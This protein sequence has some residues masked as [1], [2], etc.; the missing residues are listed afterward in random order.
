MS[1]PI[2]TSPGRSGFGPVLSLSYDSGSGNGPFGFGWSLSTPSIT[3]KTDKGL[4][5]Y[6]DKDESDVYVLSGAEDLVPVLDS[7]GKRFIDD[8]TIPGYTI[9]RYRPRVE[10]LFAQIERWTRKDDGDIH[11]RSIS[12]DNILTIYGQGD[13]DAR[14]S[15]P[16]D[17]QRIFAWLICE[18]RDDKGNAVV[19]DYKA[20]DGAGTDI[21]RAHQR[22]RG[23]RKDPGR[24]ANRYLKRIRYGNRRTLLDDGKRP[25][26]F[27][28]EQISAAGWMF[29]VVFDYGEHDA[30][31]P[32][33]DDEGEW[34]T[35]DDPFS[36]YRSGFE[37]RTARLCRRVLM[38]HHFPDE[39]GVGDNCL[40]RS[41]DFTYSEQ[42][43]P[44]RSSGPVYTFLCAATQTGYQRA[45]DGYRRRSLPPV[46]FEYTK[47]VIQGVVE[48]ADPESIEN[49]PIGLDG[50]AYRWTDLHGEGIPGILSEQAGTWFYKRNLSPIPETVI[51]GGEKVKARFAALEIVAL[52]PN[53]SLNGEAE[54]MDLAGDGR[55]DVV[56]MDGLA[57]GLYGHDDA[58]GWYPFRS[59]TAPLNRELRD[60][61]AKFIDLDGDGHA[62]LLITEDGAFVWH[63]SLAE[64]GFSTARRVA[65]ALD[66]EKGPRIVFAD[67]TQSIYLADLSGDGLTDIVRL[68]NGEVCYWPNLGYGRFGAKVTMDNSPWF[69]QQDQFDQARIRLADIDG[70]GTTDIIY[71]HRDG[72]RLYFNQSGNGWSLPKLLQVFPRVHDLAGIVPLDLLGNGTA[73]LVWSSPLQGD[74]SRPLSY[75]NLVGEHKPHLLIG[76]NNNLGAETRI[77]YAPSTKF[78]LQDK[79]DGRPWITR[80][81]F[82]V[83]VV[84]RVETYDH[85]SRSRFATRYAYH[86]G[87]FDGVEREFRGF[88]MVEQWDTEQF[89]V[90]AGG[91]IPADNI[92]AASHVP[93]IHTKSWFHTGVY[94]RRDHVSDYFAGLL[95][96]TDQGE[97]FR[98]QGLT[99]AEARALLLP[100]TILPD[101][102]TSKEEREACRALKGSM[103]RQEVYAD[104]A[105]PEATTEQIRRAA[106][107]YTV[108]E[109]SFAI[110][111]L[112]RVGVNRHAVIFVHSCEAISYHYE[113][114]SADPRTQ[115][116][117]TLEVDEVGN[118]RKQAVIG[119]G[120][121]TQIRIIN[122]EGKP[123]LV[124]NF[125]L[126]E[127]HPTDQA[128]QTTSLLTY[129]ES[130]FTEAIDDADAYRSP[131]PC[132]AITFEL[133]GYEAT[134]P[135]GRF[136][137]SDLVEPNPD[138][139]ATERFLHRFAKPDVAYEAVA[140]GN[141]RRRPIEKLRTLYRRDDLSGLLPLGK[142]EPLALPGESYKLALTPGLLTQVFQRRRPDQTFEDLLPD[143]IRPA[144]LGGL[145]GDQ[146]GYV[147]SQTLKADGRFPENDANDHWWVPSG[148]LFHHPDDALSHVELAEARAHFFLPR[149]YHD[150]FGHGAV[151]DFDAHDLLMVEARDALNN[152]VTADINDYRVLQPRRISDPN[153]NQT[154][155]AFDIL[156]MVAGTAVMGKPD[157]NPRRGDNLAGFNPDLAQVELDAFIAAPCQPN[158]DPKRTEAAPIVHTLLQGATTRIVYDLDRYKRVGEPPFAA[159]IVRE[160]H[161]CDLLPG[162]KSRL[163]IS[164]TYS[165]GFGREIQKKIQAE[166]GALDI[167]DPASPVVNPRW[168]GSGWTIF[169][170]K[171]KP[172]RQY[173]P[174]FDD[175]HAFKFATIHGVSPVL[176][177]DPAE[178]VIATLHPNHTYTKVKF[179]PWQQ[180]SWDVN[181]TCAPP[182]Q[183]PGDPP[184]HETGD[185]RTDP[186]ILGVVA[187]YFKSLAADPLGPWKTWHAQRIGGGLGTEEKTAAEQAAAHADTPTTVHFDTLGRP[188]LTV[189]RNRVVCEG[190][191]LHGKPDEEFRN[192]VEL[193]IEG[194]QRQVFDERKLPDANNL[195]LGELQQRVIMQYAYDM[196]SNRIYQLSME[197]GAR[198]M[199]NDVSGKPICAWDSRGHKFT[200]SYDALRRPIEQYVRGA[201]SDADPLKPN[202]DPRTLN[203]PSELGL[204]VDK[205]EY[206]EPPL[207]ATAA[208]DVEAQRLNLRT[209]IVRHSDSA[210]IAT[211]ARLDAN[212]KPTEAY[213][214][215]GNLLRS[216]RQ[217][218][219]DYKAIPDWLQS[220][221]IDNETFEGSTRY[222]ALNRPIQSVAPRSS[223]GRGKFNVIQPVFNEANLLEGLNVWLER[224]TSPTAL[225]DPANELPSPVGVADID[226]DAKGQRTRIDY[227]TRDATV[228]RTTYA[229][230]RDT[231]R[232]THLYTRRGVNPATAQGVAFTDD[233]D[234]PNPPPATIAAP[235]TPP[236][237]K[238][239][240][241]QSLHYTYDPVGNITRIRDDAQQ[242]LYFKNRRVE[243]H[244]DYVYD[245]LYRLIQAEGREHLGQAGAPIPHAYNDAGRVGILSANPAGRFSP[246][247]HSAMGH[248]AERYVYDAVGNFLQMQHARDHTVVSDWTRVYDYGEASLIEAGKQSNRMI[249]ATIGSG[250]PESYRH[251]AHGNMLDAPHLQA[252]QWDYRD[253]FQ[254]AQRQKI[255]E[256]DVH[257]VERQGERTWYIYSA[258]GQRL[259]KVTE[260]TNSGGMKD[261]RVYLGEYE[262][263]R[264][265]EGAANA[266]LVK[267]ER[268]TLHVM[269]DKQTVAL[270]EVRTLGGEEGIQKQ[271]IR[272]Q[273]GNQV[274]SSSLEMDE[275]AQIISYEEYTPYGSSTYQAVRSQETAKRYRYAGKERDEESG[276][277][278]HGARHYVPWLGIWASCEPGREPADGTNTYRYCRSNPVMWFDPNGHDP[279]PTAPDANNRSYSLSPEEL[280]QAWLKTNNVAV[281]ELRDLKMTGFELW[282]KY[283]WKRMRELKAAAEKMPQE[284]FRTLAGRLGYDTTVYLQ[285]SGQQTTDAGEANNRTKSL[286]PGTPIGGLVGTVAYG[287]ANALGASSETSMQALHV[288]GAVGGLAEAALPAKSESHGLVPPRGGAAS[289]PQRTYAVHPSG[290]HKPEPLKM[291]GLGPQPSVNNSQASLPGRV[292]AGE[293]KTRA[294]IDDAKHIALGKW[295]AQ[296]RD[297][298][299]VAAATYDADGNIS[300]DIYLAGWNQDLVWHNE[301]IGHIDATNLPKGSE[302][303]SAKFGTDIEPHVV[304]FIGEY[305]GQYFDVKHGNKTGNDMPP[306]G[307]TLR[308][309][310]LK[311]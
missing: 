101:G 15:D 199:L 264:S 243:P 63:R 254:W 179:D 296:L 217:L 98:E 247:D 152:R 250:P 113:R 235:Q 68:R 278:Y 279:N 171:G 158:A 248:Y 229:Y 305:L 102:L 140:T 184:P 86:H 186:D 6:N 117:L 310:L 51:E 225:L 20:E 258:S 114:D 295:G 255:N 200:T 33:P 52:K 43:H 53:V 215:K 159:T 120:R 7:N 293:I 260:L 25:R 246:N 276:M 93:P 306:S 109:Q 230:D 282:D 78:Y 167:N 157:E 82:P 106:T 297:R 242:T 14:I 73:C 256:Q 177:Y 212:G 11:W 288:G 274:G 252:M 203:L 240:G 198:W 273:F 300:L 64:E 270:V 8:Q 131:C 29:D 97:Y 104:D 57:S 62:D 18:T 129:T 223:L 60:P 207:G 180:T 265:Y 163:Q 1:L 12:K 5:Q 3:R 311:K 196:L 115:H 259:R 286:D 30:F 166:P 96:T 269:D 88:G 216:T 24:T 257:G 292:Q 46:E 118:V 133:T 245:A 110:R 124:S 75:V 234:N 272:Y 9:Q 35:R 139:D 116:A 72:V 134:G 17:T 40:V 226:Y 153:R 178:R 251:D 125:G 206:G 193:D 221:T 188:F 66:E 275:Q 173:E 142:L 209:R 71:L 67:V 294:S 87:H 149:R 213:D 141:Q 231:F 81:P 61:N 187:E 148:R 41:T 190:H 192:R 263:F 38:F 70:S 162:A 253:Q 170:N 16:V 154:E 220:P 283:G 19:Y 239:C 182:V 191:L 123:E 308:F 244:N 108:T 111:P 169:N 160:T 145:S 202:S 289:K 150:P 59:F 301:N 100:D 48:E 36:S 222:D 2:A 299:L 39:S 201:Y 56:V 197:A 121:R 26:F 69:D 92:A 211:N 189:A 298:Q 176:F 85:I 302:Y 23:D 107:P 42:Q 90:L 50:N 309:N 89:A 13:R 105:G 95:N 4:P 175:T 146:G 237:G 165:D 181:D 58:E 219:S 34:G 236:A 127:L 28:A 287:G 27:T 91:N 45:A 37:I 122:A 204:L 205:I 84:E 268:E 130:Q 172:V 267:L 280:A 119:Y 262:V 126:A 136:Q 266:R 144:V 194:N 31:N 65:Q 303:Q 195:P 47:P 10:G 210:G 156:G 228:I 112:Q 218:V 22:N 168:V 55:P 32:T 304:R 238:G 147:L 80:L 208:Q 241:L 284:V 132:E 227:K 137:A 76:S 185:P 261:E 103:L 74:A 233:C 94:F 99:D 174:S 307:Q 183:K 232:L 214:F 128:K 281:G 44:T 83:H 249:R 135:G 21:T 285:P 161:V 290:A 143:A 49:L 155:V 151:V 271:L 77:H 54:I 164:F 138:P 79:L 224:A 291:G 277:Y